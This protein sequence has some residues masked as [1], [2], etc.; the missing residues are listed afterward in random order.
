MDSSPAPSI[1]VVS[2]ETPP[3]R[4]IINLKK[5]LFEDITGITVNWEVVPLDQVLAKVSQDAATQAGAN[6]IYYFDQAWVGRFINDT[7]DPRELLESKPD[8]AMPNYNIDDFLE[9]LVLHIATYGDKMIGFPCDVP[10]F[11][12]FYRQDIYDELGLK[13]A[14]T[15]EEYLATPR[16]STRPRAPTGTYG[17]VGQMKSGHYALECDMTAYVWSHGGSVF[18]ADGMC[19]LNDEQAVTGVDYMR[20]LQQYMPAAVTTYDWGGQFTAIQ[21]GQGGQVMTW[22]EDFP[23]WDD[24]DNSK[25]SGLMQ[26]AAVAGQ[27]GAA[28]SRKKPASKRSPISDTRAAAPTACPNTPRSP[29]RPGSSCSGRPAP[30]PRR[31]PRSSAAAPARCGN[32]PSTIRA[33]RRK[34]RSVPARPVTSLKC[35]T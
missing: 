12:Y 9:P 35:S 5:A 32:R 28:R 34:K 30:T 4:A 10:I 27:R 22:G 15:M 20:E 13:P 21:Q 2:E 1:K 25:V 33:S 26:P 3:S 31:S 6:D 23:G 24:P 11:M 16:R 18:T 29:T 17:T 8:L 14:T 7:F 19:S